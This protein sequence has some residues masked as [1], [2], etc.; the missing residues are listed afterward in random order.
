[1]PGLRHDIVIADNSLPAGSCGS[2]PDG[3]VYCG[4]ANDFREFSAWECLLEAHCRKALPTYDLAALTTNAWENAPT[5][6]LKDITPA[7]LAYAFEHN[8]ALGHLDRH[9]GDI[10][11]DGYD[12]GIWLRSCLIILPAASLLAFGSLVSVSDPVRIFSGN[13]E[14]PFLPDCGLSENYQDALLAWLCGRGRKYHRQWHK[15]FNLTCQTMPL[16][17]SKA[18][19]I[20]NEAM[21]SFRLAE[22]GVRLVD[23]SWLNQALGRGFAGIPSSPRDQLRELYP[24]DEDGA[25]QIS[26]AGGAADTGSRDVKRDCRAAVMADNYRFAAPRLLYIDHRMPEPDKDAG[27]HAAFNMLKIWSELG[28]EIDFIPANL[29]PMQG[30]SEMLETE[31]GIKCHYSEIGSIEEFIKSRPNYYDVICLVRV[32]IAMPHFAAIRKYSPRSKIM[33]NTTDLHFLRER[34]RAKLA[35]DASQLEQSR[36]TQKDELELIAKC[37]L[38]IVVSQHEWDVVADLGLGRKAVF[39]PLL[40]GDVA[41]SPPAWRERRDLVFIGGYEHRPNVDAVLYFYREIFPLIRKRLPGIKFHVAGSKPPREI[42]DLARD[43]DVIVHG[44]VRDLASLFNRVR[45]SV[46]P[47][48]YGAGIKGKISTSLAFGVPVVSTAIGGESMPHG[49]GTGVLNADTAAEFADLVIGLYQDE[50]LW[51]YESRGAL[52]NAYIEY[53][54]AAGKFRQIDFLHRLDPSL[55]LFETWSLR[56][57]EEYKGFSELAKKHDSKCRQFENELALGDAPLS[58]ICAVC[59]RPVDFIYGADANGEINW[60][61]SVLCQ[62]CRLNN[63]MRAA[64]HYFYQRLNPAKDSRIYIAEQLTRMY[65]LLKKRHPNLVG[66]EYLGADKPFGRESN[67]IRNEDLQNLSFANGSF[68]FL[69]NFDVLEHVPDHNKCLSEM[70]RVLRPGGVLL[71]SAPFGVNCGETVTRAVMEP[72]G[73]ITHI[74]PPEIHGNPTDPEGGSLSFRTFGWSLLDD[75]RAAGFGDAWAEIYWSKEYGYLGAN[76][77][78]F[79]AL[80]QA[81]DSGK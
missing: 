49:K 75:L 52:K 13:P 46:A 80:K 7:A 17:I 62:S 37:D 78:L 55:P 72:D 3:G 73:S 10:K 42:Q 38:S 20:F 19:A 59:R 43:T 57:F 48:R 8:C 14:Q 34:R 47:L 30:Y 81:H 33:F 65:S 24:D 29:V 61:E 68:D 64:L 11:L 32:Y 76:Q 1:M 12:V 15:A 9:R 26:I 21:L 74:L 27:S 2:L 70:C 58:G 51:S 18:M 54:P 28:F 22:A 56:S 4:A 5:H 25:G 67:G 44:Y 53:S 40:F 66:S 41:A 39:V 6:W 31:L 16:F 79:V 63:R 36:L 69:L 35:R 45:L 50:K 23:V 77:T 71:F 60:R